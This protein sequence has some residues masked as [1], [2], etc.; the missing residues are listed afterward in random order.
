M[1]GFPFFRK[2]SKIPANFPENYT[3]D[4]HSHFIPGIDDGIRTAEDAVTLLAAL[5]KAGIRKVITTPHI[6]KEYYNN[7]HE[8]IL[9][10]LQKV[11]ELMVQQGLSIDLQ[12]AAEYM[13]DDGFEERMKS[14]PL[15]S[16]GKNYI[17]TELSYF[18]PHPSLNN[19]LFELQ[20][21]GYRVIL[22]HP[23]RYTFW[24]DNFSSYEKLKAREV[25]FQINIMSLTGHYGNMP[26]KIARKLIDAGMAEFAGSD[27]HGPHQL[28]RLL[29]A[30]A[31]PWFLKL[32]SSPGFL[33]PSLG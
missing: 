10:G 17:L 24:Y 26:K 18:T 11:T 32:I 33:N 7:S 25:F 15:L 3:I 30:S 2:K 19:N 23:E 21:A 1:A 16:F 5:E 14:G 13:I 9:A 31:D 4:F 29:Q 28:E 22:A 6:S 20:K 8:D 27:L 12:A